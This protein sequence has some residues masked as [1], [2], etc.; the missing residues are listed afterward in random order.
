MT[1]EVRSATDD[2]DDLATIA[3]IV[4]TAR[5]DE[6]TSVEEMRWSDATYPGGRRFIATLDGQAVGV[7]TVGRIYIYPPEFEALWGTVDVLPDDRRRG[8]GAALL[9][10]LRTATIDAD[11]THLH[12]P[13]SDGRPDGVSF[14]LHRGFTEYERAAMVELRLAGLAR[15]S[16]SVPAG[17]HLTT[18]AARPELVAGVHAVA[19]ATFADIPG[20]D[21]PMAAGDLAEFR[22]RDVDRDTIPRWG[23]IVALD[24]ATDE[25]VGYASLAFNP[26]ST[27]VA[28]HDMTAVLQ[29]WRGR[30]VATTLKA[31]TI[32]AAL[33][34][35]VERLETGNDLDNAP[36]RAVNARLGYRPLPDWLTMRGPARSGIMT[37]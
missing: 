11:K 1:I 22:A 35:G 26:G 18:L 33:D 13:A 24:D 8:A 10:T 14:L 29:A 31:A 30:G 6:P 5:P 9:E 28:Y 27:T 17:I 16:S 34:H 12:V 37:P 20:A 21:D 4:T 15:P 3:R 23:F 19:L 25:V 32:A 2:H 7:G 36:M